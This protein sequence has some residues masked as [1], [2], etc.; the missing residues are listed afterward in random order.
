MQT[1]CIKGVDP[2]R[3]T[4]RHRLSWKIRRSFAILGIQATGMSP[5]VWSCDGFQWR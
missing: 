5:G 3:Y 4:R 2:M 1:L